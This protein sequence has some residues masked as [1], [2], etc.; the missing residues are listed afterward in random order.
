MCRQI[1][2]YQILSTLLKSVYWG[3]LAG[4]VAHA[5]T[6]WDYGLFSKEMK[7]NKTLKMLRI[8]GKEQGFSKINSCNCCFL[9]TGIPSTLLGDAGTVWSGVGGTVCKPSEVQHVFPSN[10]T[11]SILLL[12][13]H[14]L[15]PITTC[16]VS[17][18]S[19]ENPH[20]RLSRADSRGRATWE[21]H[22]AHKS[23]VEFI[24]LCDKTD[25]STQTVVY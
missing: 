1:Y 20:T 14:S 25:Y 13:T 5:S 24:S 2:V 8:R 10:W 7:R 16:A 22:T 23:L 17:K 3:C 12:P 18:N 6:L 21:I 11:S 9:C 4:K 15:T 19:A